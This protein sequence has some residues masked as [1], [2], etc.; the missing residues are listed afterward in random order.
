MESFDRITYKI[1]QLSNMCLYAEPLFNDKNNQ[2]T[3]YFRSF[4]DYDS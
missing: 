2:I 1:W 3:S 4:L